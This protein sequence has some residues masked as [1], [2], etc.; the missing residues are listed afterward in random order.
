MIFFRLVYLE[1]STAILQREKIFSWKWDLTKP[2]PGEHIFTGFK[3]ATDEDNTAIGVEGALGPLRVH[4]TRHAPQQLRATFH[5]DR[6]PFNSLQA[7]EYFILSEVQG[8]NVTGAG[9]DAADSE[10]SSAAAVPDAVN[11]PVRVTCTMQSVHA[12]V[13][14]LCEYTCACARV[15]TCVRVFYVPASLLFARYTVSLR[16]YIYATAYAISS[17]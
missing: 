5:A 17:R 8:G 15:R 3:I 12:T 11:P 7:S 4:H 9:A 1:A 14:G 13:C 6:D 2:P 10:D 16:A